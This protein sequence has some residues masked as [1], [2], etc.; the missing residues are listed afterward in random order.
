MFFFLL[1]K[2]LKCLNAFDWRYKFLTVLQILSTL[3]IYLPIHMLLSM[4]ILGVQNMTELLKQRKTAEPQSTTED[5][6]PAQHQSIPRHSPEEECP[7][8]LSPVKTHVIVE[9][10]EIYDRETE[11]VLP[12][13]IMMLDLILK[14]VYYQHYV[15][16]FFNV[17]LY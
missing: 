4:F 9:A 15:L 3:D 10:F 8:P 7:P 5:S 1:F 17:N 11:L 14:Q 2:C 6:K 12:C 13:Y 16:Y